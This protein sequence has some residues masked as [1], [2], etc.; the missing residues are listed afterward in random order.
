MQGFEKIKS[1]N[2]TDETY[3]PNNTWKVWRYQK[4]IPKT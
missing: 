4:G 3:H 2:F 1:S